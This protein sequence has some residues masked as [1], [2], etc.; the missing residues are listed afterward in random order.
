MKNSRV[1]SLICVPILLSLVAI[2]VMLFLTDAH[3]LMKLWLTLLVTLALGLLS[4]VV[5]DMW[6][7]NL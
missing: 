6:R 7:S 5:I 3:V 4:W 1:M 2:I